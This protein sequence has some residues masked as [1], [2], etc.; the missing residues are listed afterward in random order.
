MAFQINGSNIIDNSRNLTAG[1]V[2]EVNSWRHW[3]TGTSNSSGV[4]TRGGSGAFSWTSG[5][6]DLRSVN[7]Y[8]TNTDFTDAIYRFKITAASGN[9]GTFSAFPL[10]QVGTS[11]AWN[12]LLLNN[13]TTVKVGSCFYLMIKTARQS[14]S[15][16]SYAAPH[17]FITAMADTNSNTFD[18]LGRFDI[19]EKDNAYSTSGGAVSIE[20]PTCGTSIMTMEHQ[21]WW[22]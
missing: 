8:P 4:Y 12:A 9:P 17:S 18:I 15:G 5:T 2:E 3:T 1:T 16:T 7:V 10:Y 14:I 22:R 20:W 21:V 19:T 6:V 13:N 11:M